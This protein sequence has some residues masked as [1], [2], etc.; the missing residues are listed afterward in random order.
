MSAPEFI[1]DLDIVKPKAKKTYTYRK[2]Y[3]TKDGT[4]KYCN[5]TVS[6]SVSGKPRGRPKKPIDTNLE[7]EKKVIEKEEL[8]LP[9]I[10]E[11][12]FD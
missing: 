4:V 10:V 9:D 8:K 12:K 7:E 5:Q 3:V 6:A 11:L 2:S 1:L